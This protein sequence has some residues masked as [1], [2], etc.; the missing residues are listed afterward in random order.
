MKHTLWI[1]VLLLFASCHGVSEKQRTLVDT[2][3]EQA[4]HVRYTDIDSTYLL[5]RKAYEEAG[6]YR[7][8]KARALNM[9]IYVD[10][11]QMDF[12]SAFVK[13][14]SVRHLSNNQVILL[15]SDVLRMKINQR[16]GD[17]SAYFESRISAQKRMKRVEEEYEQLSSVDRHDYFF[18]RTEFHIIS[19]TYC[20]YQDQDQEAIAEMEAIADDFTVVTDSTQWLYYNYMMGSGGLV[21]GTPTEISL[22]EFDYLMI[23]WGFSRTMKVTY[24]EANSLQ[25]LASL[26][27]DASTRET[28]QQERSDL[29]DLLLNQHRDWLPQDSIDMKAELSEALALHAVYSFREYKDLFQTAC[30]YRTLGEMAFNHGHYELALD[31]YSMAL[32]CVNEQYIYNNPGHTDHLL[33]LYDEGEDGLN[34]VELEWIEADSVYTV[35]EW[36]AGIRQKISMAFSALGMKKESDYNRNIYLDI[37]ARTSQNVEME[38]RMAQLQSEADSLRLRLVFT[39]LL[40]L[41]L[42]ALIV[43]F[44]YHLRKRNEMHLNARRKEA[45]PDSVLQSDASHLEQIRDAIEEVEEQTHLCELKID[46]NKRRNAEKRAKVSLVHAVTPF[47]D[48]IINQTDRMNREGRMDQEKLDYVIEL[49]DR[50]VTYNDI[51]TD[52]I[53]MEKGDLSLQITTIELD[54]IFQTLQRGH[55]TFDQKGVSL[56]VKPTDLTVKAD[57]ALTLFMLNTL[58][59]NARKFTPEGGSVTISAEGF[60]EY[61]ELS[62]TDTGCGMKPE[63]VDTLNNSKVYDAR[64]IGLT[65]ENKGFGFGIMNCRGIIEKY[66]KTSSYFQHCCFG[67]ESE[68]GKG[69]RFFFRLPRVLMLLMALILCPAIMQGAA[70]S[71]AEDCYHSSYQCN[72]RGDYEEAI[73]YGIEGLHAVHPA[74]QLTREAELSAD[75]AF[76]EVDLFL[77]GDSLN[78]QVAIS[79]R[80]EIAI[81]SLALNEWEQYRY[82]NTLCTSL[83]KLYH[84][85]RNLPTYCE[86]LQRTQTTSRQLLVL[87]VMFS[88][89]IIVL[90]LI[91]LR[92]RMYLGRGLI[93]Q[94]QLCQQ[95]EHIDEESLA[96][97]VADIQLM[98]LHLLHTT[99]EG[100]NNW[101]HIDGMS[102]CINKQEDEPMFDLSEGECVGASTIV[103]LANGVGALTLHGISGHSDENLN[104]LVY[105]TLANILQNRIILPAQALEEKE[106]KEEELNHLR[107]EEHRLHVQ[108][109]VLDNCLST[110]KHESMYYP[111]RIM[112]LAQRRDDLPQLTE[113]S[114]YYKDVYTLLSSQAEKLTN[115]NCYRKEKLDVDT[116][117]A[118][119]V[120]HF[121]K[122]ANKKGLDTQLVLAEPCTSEMSL[123]ADAILIEELFVRFNTTFVEWYADRCFAPAYAD[124][125]V[126][127]SGANTTEASPSLQVV[128][129]QGML[130]FCYHLS[131]IVMDESQTHTLFYPESRHINLLIAKQIIREMDALHNFP[132]LRLMAEPRDGY[133]NV[134]C[135]LK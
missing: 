67:V 7:D 63:D 76:N 72:Q 134:W 116:V 122:L 42:T 35:P 3:N 131:G 33:S 64:K 54:R 81:A 128:P 22:K 118:K 41:A 95:L 28:I 87:L 82:N 37:I 5:A 105:N 13:L 78:Y 51:L 19:S 15:V 49:T 96:K 83:Y 56:I 85:D 135:T 12:S 18:A 101:Q 123:H 61:V 47:L 8:G 58:A 4:Y 23:C 52:W 21:E 86:R 106:M 113:L 112:Q 48:R 84:Q 9:L 31:N 39:A 46:K 10:Y 99:F 50:I 98:A 111:A 125:T 29:F 2:L 32:D 107:Y 115:Q 27:S 74:L 133:I 57:E 69:S 44:S 70:H 62:V 121:N 55:Y 68:L 126:H 40:F 100:M 36:I 73:R 117:L 25:A 93:L 26:L 24:F 127:A 109:Q 6:A 20:Y 17:G 90:S 75:T 132:G 80:N 97:D 66:R 77:R 108:N 124:N 53:K 92:R 43:S 110:I 11:Q 14:D 130:R 114:S 79:L 38:S 129:T 65:A 104:S 45:A 94:Q 30:A 34:E 1:F 120:R 16:I 91:L 71:T 60:D 59:D 119:A 89:L 102:L 103:E 88:G